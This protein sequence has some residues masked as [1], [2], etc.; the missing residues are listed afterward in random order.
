MRKQREPS[1][2]ESV[3]TIKRSIQARGGIATQD[4]IL[5]AL[6]WN[7]YKHLTWSERR[8]VG[9]DMPMAYASREW[10]E[11]RKNFANLIELV[12]LKTMAVS[13]LKRAMADGVCNLV[14]VINPKGEMHRHCVLPGTEISM[15]G[16]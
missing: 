5:E 10:I 3:K 4:R 8:K 16:A 1:Y 7:Y 15:D 6:V 14:E 11:F 13:M 12:P 9:I 2:E